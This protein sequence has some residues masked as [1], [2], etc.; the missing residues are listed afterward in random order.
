MPSSW[1][2]F[3]RRA[4][5]QRTASTFSGAALIAS[6]S[7]LPGFLIRSAHAAARDPSKSPS[8]STILVIVQLTGGNDGLNTVIP[9][10]DDRYHNARPTLRSAAAGSHHLSDSLALHPDMVAFKRLHDGGLLSVIT[11][12]GYPNPDRSHFRAMDIWHTASLAPEQA[13]DGWLGRSVDRLTSSLA[14]D[15]PSPAALHL[16]DSA[17]PL[18]LQSQ[19]NA[20]PSISSLDSLRLSA[21]ARASESSL[22]AALSNP[23]TDDLLFVRRV[24][25]SSCA[26][27][28]RIEQVAARNDSRDS[29]PSYP[30]AS[31][32]RQIARLI[33][34]DFGARIYYTSL[35]GFD[36][37]SGQSLVHGSLLREL[38][39]S[40]AAFN[41]DVSRLGLA[42]RVLCM[43]FSEF[44]R[45]LNE[46]GSQGTDHGAAAPMFLIGRNLHSGIIGSAP[47][48]ADLDQGDVRFQ[49]DF[50]SVYAAVLE[51]WLH[52]DSAAVLGAPGAPL[53]LF[54][55]A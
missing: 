10:A 25:L 16:D 43:T 38:A 29:Y 19:T 55:P 20:V 33:E 13:R 45:R 51:R 1:S 36:T 24:A 26:N 30:L 3:S 34:S 12:V 39:E 46:N 8:D 7:T 44:G 40:L 42:D 54:T 18:A 6:G 22:R 5:L 32:L 28:R 21:G 4:F 49:T 50:R 11:N 37:H 47:N 17:L 41:A 23:A 35:A 31:R 9:F 48:L 53:D 14:D 27:A 2:T 52:L 15:A